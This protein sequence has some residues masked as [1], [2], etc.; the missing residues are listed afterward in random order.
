MKAA[1][2]GTCTSARDSQSS[3]QASASAFFGGI[4]SLSLSGCRSKRNPRNGVVVGSYLGRRGVSVWAY[5]VAARQ[6]FEGSTDDPCLQ[7]ELATT[8]RD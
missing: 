3:S 1:K 5:D 2:R 7:R 4:L 6:Y 8:S